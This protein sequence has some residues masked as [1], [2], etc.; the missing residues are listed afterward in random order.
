MLG[1]ATILM[2]AKINKALKTK[3]VVE[4][5]FDRKNSFCA[6]KERTAQ[7]LKYYQILFDLY[8]SA[9]RKLRKQFSETKFGLDP[10]KIFHEKYN[11]ALQALNE[12]VDLYMQETETG[13]QADA[14]E[15]WSKM[16]QMELKELHSFSGESGKK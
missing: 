4:A 13:E 16:V 2:N 14:I 3:T 7:M 10:E 6:E 11:A 9:S 12:R 1:Y 5:V 8:E 15:K